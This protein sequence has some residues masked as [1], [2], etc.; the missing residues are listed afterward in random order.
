MLGRRRERLEARRDA[1]QQVA[2]PDQV[3]VGVV[4]GIRR[5]ERPRGDRRQDQDGAAPRVRCAR[6][7]RGGFGR[8]RSPR[9]RERRADRQQHPRERVLEERRV[10]QRVHDER[11]ERRGDRRTRDRLARA[12]QQPARSRRRAARG[13][14]RARRAPCSAATVIGIVC[15][16]A[17]ARALDVFS[18]RRYSRRKDPAPQ[19]GDRP[20]ARE[21]DA[22][23]DERRAPA[24]DGV[25]RLVDPDR[26]RRREHDDGAGDRER[27]RRPPRRDP[28]PSVSA[29]STVRPASSAVNDDCE[30]VST[31]PAHSSTSAP[32]QPATIGVRRPTA[33]RAVSP[34]MTVARK[35]P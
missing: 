35:R 32:A 27:G 29:P 30:S 23:R 20:V 34:S 12:A 11:D 4:V 19:P 33:A 17:E 31:R 22:A 3:V 10:Q 26:A 7:R 16:A 1:V 24:R 13:R 9:S 6:S 5:H 18:W 25:G 2:T 28:R 15:D 8:R 14:A 21:L